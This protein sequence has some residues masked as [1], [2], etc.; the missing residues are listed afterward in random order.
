MLNRL[1]YQVLQ[2]DSNNDTILRENESSDLINDK[3]RYRYSLEWFAFVKRALHNLHANF[4]NNQHNSLINMTNN[5]KTEKDCRRAELNIYRWLQ[6]RL[7]HIS[8]K[9]A[10]FIRKL[11][12]I[13]KWCIF[14]LLGGIL[15]TEFQ[16]F[17]HPQNAPKSAFL[18]T[19]ILRTIITSRPAIAGNPRCKNITAKSVHLTSLYHPTALTSSRQMIIWVFYVTMFVLNAKLCSI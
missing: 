8:N 16:P 14:W 11:G 6:G 3:I 15:P 7:A 5:Q 12:G 19:L 17:L 9:A 13:E 1:S 18:E 2:D 10:C 4:G